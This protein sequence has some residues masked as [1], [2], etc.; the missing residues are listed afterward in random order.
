VD[1]VDIEHGAAVAAERHV[2]HGNFDDPL[3]G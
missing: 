3:A 2:G 1:V